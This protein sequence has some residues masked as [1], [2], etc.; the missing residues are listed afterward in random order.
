MYNS[1]DD[2][3]LFV[4]LVSELAPNPVTATSGVVGPTLGC[5]L[6]ENFSRV[7]H[8]DNYFYESGR[9]P[10][11]FTLSIILLHICNLEIF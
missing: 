7:K 5:L 6:G 8:T 4:G 10:N 3:D 2:I 9:L 1:V 11:R